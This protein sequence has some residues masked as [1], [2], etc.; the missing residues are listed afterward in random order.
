VL[1]HYRPLAAEAARSTLDAVPTAGGET[2]E[3]DVTAILSRLRVAGIEHAIVV[4]LPHEDLPASVARVVVPGL[5][6]ASS[7]PQYMRG[8]RAEAASL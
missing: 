7:A 5:E 8:R 3:D 4:P 1:E 6:G 2:V